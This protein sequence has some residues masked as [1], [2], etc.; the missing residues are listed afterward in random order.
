VGPVFWGVP[1]GV[2]VLGGGGGGGGG[3]KGEGKRGVSRGREGPSGQSVHSTY[4]LHVL[5]SG[6]QRPAR[7][8]ACHHMLVLLAN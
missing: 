1:R 5:G 4:Q 2:L 8:V 3:A 7:H 6:C